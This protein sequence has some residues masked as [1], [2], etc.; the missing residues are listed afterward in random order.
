MSDPKVSEPE[1]GPAS[2]LADAAHPAQEESCL[3]SNPKSS[4]HLPESPYRCRTSDSRKNSTTSAPAT[5]SSCIRCAS[6]PKP[7]IPNPESRI[8]NPESRNP[9]PKPETRNP[10]PETRNPKPET[11]NPK[12]ETRNLQPSIFTTLTPT[13][14]PLNP[15]SAPPSLPKSLTLRLHSITPERYS[16][17]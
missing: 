5:T 7:R 2:E 15:E 1:D 14:G 9:E 6:K 10:K 8:P 3:F 12:P 11:R 13:P 17:R 4:Q 16:P